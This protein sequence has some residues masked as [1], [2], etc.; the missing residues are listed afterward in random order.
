[1]VLG[2]TIGRIPTT[3]SLPWRALFH[4][5]A[6]AAG[7]AL[8]HLEI[9]AGKPSPST[10][11]PDAFAELATAYRELQLVIPRSAVQARHAAEDFYAEFD[12]TLDRLRLH[13]PRPELLEI[14]LLRL[15]DLH[16]R[17]VPHALFV[18]RRLIWQIVGAMLAGI[19]GYAFFPTSAREALGHFSAPAYF[20]LIGGALAAF[21]A[22]IVAVMLKAMRTG[23]RVGSVGVFLLMPSLLNLVLVFALAYWIPADAA[24]ACLNVPISRVDALYFSFVTF[25]TTGFG[26]FYPTTATCRMITTVQMMTTFVVITSLLGMYIGLAARTRR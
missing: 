6:L 8:H 7:A 23:H 18:P 3:R 22:L 10:A 1:M 2:F 26:D 15:D 14:R 13:G 5:F 9:E 4:R 11:P 20:A 21:S 25:T 19:L 24:N 17:L 12:K 16:D